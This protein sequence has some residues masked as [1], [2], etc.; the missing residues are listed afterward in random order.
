MWQCVYQFFLGLCFWCPF[1]SR[2]Q[3]LASLG[4]I[5]IRRKAV[6]LVDQ[7]SRACRWN[8]LAYAIEPLRSRKFRIFSRRRYNRRFPSTGLVIRP[9][10][11][12]NSRWR[13]SEARFET[14]SQRY[15][16]LNLDRFF[17]V[18]W[19]LHY[20]TVFLVMHADAHGIGLPSACD[21]GETCLL[22]A[23]V[24]YPRVCLPTGEGNNRGHR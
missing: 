5:I 8:V 16:S 19:R 20:L 12:L 18:N 15:A 22:N 10:W 2:F 24:M 14:C 13:E 17:K 1:S 7:I 9:H 21:G 4:S 23:V 6:E 11:P 3:S